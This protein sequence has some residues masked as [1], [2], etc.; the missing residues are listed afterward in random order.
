MLKIEYIFKKSDDVIIKDIDNESVLL[1]LKSGDYFT[2]NATGSAILE[3]LNGS[4][5]IAEIAKKISMEFKVDYK[6]VVH[7]AVDFLGTL[8]KNKLIVKL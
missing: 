7:D 6:Q 1:N 2:V 8:Y 3:S 4:R 5:N